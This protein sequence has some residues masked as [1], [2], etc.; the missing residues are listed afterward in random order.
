MSVLCRIL[1]RMA[2]TLP[3]PAWAVPSRWAVL[4]VAGM[5]RAAGDHPRARGI[6]DA[7]DWAGTVPDT[8]AASAEALR[9][10]MQAGA[11]PRAQARVS[12]LYWL[13]GI[14]TAPPVAI[15]RRNDDGTLPTVA[16]LVDEA[17]AAKPYGNWL[18]EDRHA[19]RLRAERQVLE[20]QRLAALIQDWSNA[21]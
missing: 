7:L 20:Y 18:P 6:L 16:Q 5:A 21:R 8:A 2:G 3:V 9:L 1:R 12:T 14:Q 17:I 19:A 13:A 10:D 4:D 15:P 11:D